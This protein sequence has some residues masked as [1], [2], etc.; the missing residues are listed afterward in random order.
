MQLFNG[1]GWRRATTSA[2]LAAAVLL[3]GPTPDAV[4][5][6]PV[7]YGTATY[8][9]RMA[10]PQ[11]AVF[12][13][14][15]ED[16]TPTGRPAELVARTRIDPVQ[17]LPI[18]FAIPY[19]PKLIKYGNRYSIQ[20]RIVADGRLL[21]AT[22]DPVPVFVDGRPTQVDLVLPRAS[23]V[24][25]STLPAPA[26]VYTPPPAVTRVPAPPVAGLPSSP[27]GA[28]P[29]TFTGMFPCA[30]CSGIRHELDLSPNGTFAMR[31]EY[32]GRRGD[33]GFTL[34]GRWLLDPAGT[35]TL[36]GDRDRPLAFA[37]KSPST[38]RLLDASGQEIVSNL[39]Y[40]LTR[41]AGYSATTPLGGTPLGAPSQSA[42]PVTTYPST[43]SVT[44]YPST[45]ESAYRRRGLYRSAGGPP[46]FF[47]CAGNQPILVASEGDAAALEAA[48]RR[49]QGRPGQEIMAEV[50]GRI[51][52]QPLADG[53]GL[54]RV[55]TVDRFIEL[56][57]GESC[58]P[59]PAAAWTPP[60]QLG[61]VA[62]PSVPAT[63]AASADAPLRNT[64]WKLTRLGSQPVTEIAGRMEP[65]LIL[66]PDISQFSGSGG[67]NGIGGRFVQNDRSL[68]LSLGPSTQMACA[69]GMEQEQ[70]FIRDLDR[71]RTWKT[72]GNRLTFSDAYGTALLTFEAKYR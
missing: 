31:T 33:P 6:A 1:S 25:T 22:T 35:L 66:N 68:T 42:S 72:D 57:P 51:T 7:L 65:H 63:P 69:T 41:V 27:L 52:I 13:A 44:T 64:Y 40:D 19:D 47:E 5:Q 12:E 32:L 38:L 24:A 67:C 43:S 37:I 62:S 11:N 9:E 39:N 4:A 34:R 60:T 8:Y 70:S 30:D 71:T 23:G 29:A 18:R 14:T 58:A 26:P 15:V 59:P 56:R 45:A 2:A 20:A 54:G 17:E 49:E 53:S 10:L 16:V 3:G 61:P 28:L 50:E 36:S 55:L 21:F 46:Q 48:Y